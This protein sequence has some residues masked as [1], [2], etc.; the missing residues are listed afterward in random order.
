M[1]DE[2]LT[3]ALSVAARGRGTQL[4][5]TSCGACSRCDAGW[6]L[7]C[8]SRGSPRREVDVDVPH[9][10]A[11]AL[12]AAVV[13]VSALAEAAVQD[14]VVVVHDDPDGAVAAAA[15]ALRARA[16]LRAGRTVPERADGV[17][18]GTDDEVRAHL[19]DLTPTGRADVVAIAG[20]DARRALRTVVRGG[21]LAVGTAAVPA[22][23]VTEVVQ[24]ELRIAG[25]KDV[26]GVL[27]GP[28]G[29]DVLRAL[30]LSLSA[31]EQ[32]PA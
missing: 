23:T 2:G 30:A 32:E 5:D 28:A 17:V 10:R 15:A 25:P 14:R 4:L 31:G 20:G 24:R 26:V 3:L 11:Q 19:T 22:A 8:V 16:V 13:T 9:T 27:S 7:W 18:A 1:T 12:L 29:P 6:P 21:W